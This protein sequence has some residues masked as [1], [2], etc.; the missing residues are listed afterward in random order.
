MPLA[1]T[2]DELGET[3][4]LT[5]ELSRMLGQFGLACPSL[6][7]QGSREDEPFDVKEDAVDLILIK[8]AHGAISPGVSKK[9][10]RAA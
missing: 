5:L 2:S 10:L 9:K 8:R 3:T 6:L 1:A 7:Q 4:T